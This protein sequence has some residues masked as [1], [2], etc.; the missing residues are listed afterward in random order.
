MIPAEISPDDVVEVVYT[1]GTTGEPK[2]V[3]HRHRNICSNLR[4]FQTE[5]AK[6]KKWA[7]PFPAILRDGDDGAGVGS[8]FPEERDHRR[9]PVRH[10]I[11]AQNIG[12]TGEVHFG[13]GLCQPH[14]LGRARSLRF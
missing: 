3:V 6:Y 11:G 8:H 4:P 14:A 13:I 12:E 7:R 10:E 1:S 9:Q 2:G 5:I